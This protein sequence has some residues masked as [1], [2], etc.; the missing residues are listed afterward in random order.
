M[1]YMLVIFVRLIYWARSRASRLLG[2]QVWLSFWPR[3]QITRQRCFGRHFGAAGGDALS[4][5]NPHSMLVIGPFCDY[6]GW[7]ED[8]ELHGKFF[9]P[10]G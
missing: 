3:A 5:S 7:K 8:E 1:L 9:L 10:G 4:G 6:L 2:R